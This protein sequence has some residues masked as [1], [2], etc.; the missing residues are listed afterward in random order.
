MGSQM[1]L[2][3]GVVHLCLC[4]PFLPFSLLFLLPCFSLLF[5]AL[6]P[7]SCCYCPLQAFTHLF[8]QYALGSLLPLFAFFVPSSSL[9]FACLACHTS[10]WSICCRCLKM[11]GHSVRLFRLSPEMIQQ[12]LRCIVM[13]RCHH[14]FR[15]ALSCVPSTSGLRFSIEITQEVSF[16]R[17]TSVSQLHSVCCSEGG[18]VG[19]TCPSLC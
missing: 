12:H 7:L 1:L 5:E 10:S 9:V 14:A 16:M 3:H 4:R 6:L 8:F 11:D 13:L 15:V 17:N 2:C 18:K 19:E